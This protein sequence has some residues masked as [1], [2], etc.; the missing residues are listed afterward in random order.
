MVVKL[1]LT[2]YH[3]KYTIFQYGSC[4]TV[5]RNLLVKVLICADHA[6]YM[7]VEAGNIVISCFLHYNLCKVV[8]LLFCDCLGVHCIKAGKVDKNICVIH[9]VHLIKYLPSN[10]I[11]NLEHNFLILLVADRLSVE[12]P[13]ILLVLTVCLIN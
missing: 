8:N 13:L 5:F 10:I 3:L 1:E 4:R 12:H 7:I 9:S 6:K 2:F 11:V